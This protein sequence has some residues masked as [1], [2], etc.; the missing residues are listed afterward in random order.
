MKLFLAVFLFIGAQTQSAVAGPD[1]TRAAHIDQ[2]YTLAF[3]EAFTENTGETIQELI[4]ELTADQEEPI[5]STIVLDA[6]NRADME[7]IIKRSLRRSYSE[8]YAGAAIEHLSRPEIAALMQNLYDSDTDL[9]DDA[10]REDFQAFAED[11]EDNPD[12]YTERVEVVGTI[13]NR[14]QTTRISVQTME[15]FMTIIV[16]AINQTNEEDDRLTDREVNDLIIALRGNFREFFDNMLLFITLYSTRDTDMEVLRDHAAFLESDEG[17]W[18][19]RA[20]NNA[21]LNSF[22]EIS[23]RVAVEL[24]EWA[25]SREEQ[26]LE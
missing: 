11:V 2:L 6:F 8:T 3:L 21:I 7:T 19:I 23:E 22:G 9:S 5:Y 26:L 12:V 4:T 24:A 18:Y 1:D 13:I 17:R 15:D 10:L 25:L 20:Y 14:A 16:F